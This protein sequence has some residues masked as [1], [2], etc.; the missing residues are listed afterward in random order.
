MPAFLLAHEHPGGRKGAGLEG[1]PLNEAPPSW[2]KPALPS[3]GGASLQPFVLG[4]SVQ[5]QPFWPS[6]ALCRGRGASLVFLEG[7]DKLPASPPGVL[8]GSLLVIP[9]TVEMARSRKRNW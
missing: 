6:P 5:N 8:G 3:K 1:L 7:P 2:T 9:M 4:P